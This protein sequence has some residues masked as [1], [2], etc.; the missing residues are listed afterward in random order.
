M[1]G[2]D[3]V[4]TAVLSD[5]GLYRYELTRTWDIAGKR[6]CWIML[7][8]STADADLDDPTI[9]KCMGFAK[10]WGFGGIRVLNLWA[11]RTPYPSALVDAAEAGID[12]EGPLNAARLVSATPMAELVVAGWGTNGTWRNKGAKCA[13][14]LAGFGVELRCIGTTKGGQPRHPARPGYDTPLVPYRSA[15]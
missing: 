9:R 15:A 7:N 14:L 3:V 8:P 13:Q 12:V 4:K 6:C 5:C 11:Y 2:P 10:A 1:T